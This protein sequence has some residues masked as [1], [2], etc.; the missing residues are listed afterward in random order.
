M[1]LLNGEVYQLMAEKIKIQ[2]LICNSFL[3]QFFRK[4]MYCYL[5]KILNKNK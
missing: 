2:G 1:W 5:W 4:D 3:T